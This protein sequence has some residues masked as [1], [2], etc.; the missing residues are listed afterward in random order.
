M[1]HIEALLA[2]AASDLNHRAWRPCFEAVSKGHIEPVM[3]LL[4]DKSERLVTTEM[5]QPG[6]DGDLCSLLV[7]AAREQQPIMVKYLIENYV[8]PYEECQRAL[9]VACE[10]ETILA[11]FVRLAAYPSLETLYAAIARRP[12]QRNSFGGH[13]DDHAHHVQLVQVMT[14]DGV[15]SPQDL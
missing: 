5:V 9:L 2:R 11:T 10:A 6:P 7:H 12:I 13:P 4:A 14:R 15:Y 8:W 1:S 3:N